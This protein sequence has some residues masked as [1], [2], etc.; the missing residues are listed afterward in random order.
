MESLQDCAVC[1]L[2]VECECLLELMG[3]PCMCIILCF[4]AY[5]VVIWCGN[6]CLND[7]DV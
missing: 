5:S 2:G 1:L 6:V 3:W 7:L 4:V